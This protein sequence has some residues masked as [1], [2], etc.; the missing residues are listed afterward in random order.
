VIAT[1]TPIVVDPPAPYTGVNFNLTPGQ[2]PPLAPLDLSS[3]TSGFRVRLTWRPNPN[4]AAPTGYVVEAGF[5]QGTTAVTLPTPDPLLD[6]SGV[7]P[8]R[9]FVRVRARNAFGT[10]PASS[11]FVLVVN[12]DGLGSP[13]MVPLVTAWMSGRRLNMLWSDPSLGERPTSYVVE[14]G[15]A[16]GLSNLASLPV[17][18]R[19]FSYDPVPDG[20]YFVRVRARVGANPGPASRELML[21]VGSGP[22]P[23]SAPLGWT[24]RLSG[25]AVTFS[26]SAPLDGSPTSYLVEAGSMIG[27]SNL[28]VFSTGSAAT[29][30]TVPNVPSGIYYVRL[31]AVNTMGA[32]PPSYDTLIVVP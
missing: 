2:Q 23:P 30:L 17:T 5:S 7:P 31:R 18:M 26:W 1:G 27:L 22:S 4:G 10:G 8:G 19:S 6:V 15:T 11:D 3:T 20:F 24:Y 13:G 25:N 12:G 28:A 21:K 14:V 16:A 29:T 9:Y 32:G